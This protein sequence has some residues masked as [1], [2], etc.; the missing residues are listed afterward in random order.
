MAIAQTKAF[1]FCFKERSCFS[2]SFF[3][4]KR[5]GTVNLS[6]LPSWNKTACFWPL[7]TQ[8]KC[9]VQSV[10]PTS[11]IQSTPF[12]LPWIWFIFFAYLWHKTKIMFEDSLF[13]I[14]KVSC[15]GTDLYLSCNL[16]MNAGCAK[17]WCF[18][19][20]SGHVN[21]IHS[22][23]FIFRRLYLKK[24]SLFSHIPMDSHGFC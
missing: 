20:L 8:G 24:R 13:S 19:L 14:S 9:S 2:D 15:H 21:V 6:E 16:R 5:H 18:T 7:L 3:C 23:C 22:K 10:P 1:P 12:W 17:T 11:V 4:D